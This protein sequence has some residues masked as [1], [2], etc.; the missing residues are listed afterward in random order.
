VAEGTG[1]GVKAG[2]GTGAGAGAGGGVA[3]FVLF[4]AIEIPN[5]AFVF[6]EF[7][8]F[9]FVAILFCLIITPPLE[10]RSP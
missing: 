5:T 3:L 10:I 2:T 6:I 9:P 8:L 7:A 1:T 4:A